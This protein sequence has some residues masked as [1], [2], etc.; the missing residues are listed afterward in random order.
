M[1]QHC[2][3]VIPKEGANSRMGPGVWADDLMNRKSKRIRCKRLPTQ[4][5]S[6][7]E[8]HTSKLWELRTF[9]KKVLLII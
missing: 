2:N 1:H 9:M 4:M 6:K 7:S 8:L 3:N 5:F